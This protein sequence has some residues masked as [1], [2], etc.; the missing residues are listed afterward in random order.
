MYCRMQWTEHCCNL[1]AYNLPSACTMHLCWNR[2]HN[3]KEG[4]QPS[5]IAAKLMHTLFHLH[6]IAFAVHC[7][8]L[9]H[10]CKLNA[11]PLPFA[12][13]CICSALHWMQRQ[14]NERCICVAL[15]VQALP[16]FR[17]WTDKA[18]YKF[19]RAIERQRSRLQLN[20]WICS[21]PTTM[22]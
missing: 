9:Q 22:D 11:Y 16:L 19:E 5:N 10:C 14:R 4:I 3:P 7:S 12:L 17:S 21:H 1:K 6:Y 18:G 15:H 20:I 13:H 2:L 8:A